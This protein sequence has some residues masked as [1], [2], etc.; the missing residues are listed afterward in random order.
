MVKPII[1][2]TSH[3]LAGSALH[4]SM[5]PLYRLA[6]NQQ[7]VDAVEA[8]GGAVLCIPLGLGQESRLRLYS[9]LD[10]LLLP[11]GDDIDPQLYGEEPHPRL[12]SV[13]RQ[14]DDLELWFA[15]LALENDL[16]ILGICRGVQVL[17][18]VAGGSLYQ[19][20]PSQLGHARPHDVREHGRDYL[21]HSISVGLGSHL[22]VALQATETGV[23]SFHHQ[24]VRTVPDTFNVTATSSDGLIE[25]LESLHHRFVV[26]VQCHPEGMWDTTAPQF[27]GLFRDF[28]AASSP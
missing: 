5:P 22:A 15:R 2:I 3:A 18:V 10:G 25:G 12:G 20:L 4:P 19:D 21:A 26:G 17:A 28:V 7:Y 24:A 27:A 13:D 6:V 11:G 16:P 1:G 14:R 23:N 8:A 9:L